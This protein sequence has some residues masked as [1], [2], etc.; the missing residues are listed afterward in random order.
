M[1]AIK[2]FGDILD[3]VFRVFLQILVAV[4]AIIILIQ[5]I[6]RYFLQS[7][8]SWSEELAR[9]CMIWLTFIGASIALKENSLSRVDL[10]VEIM[11]ENVKKIIFIITDLIMLLI[12][13]M[14][15]KYSVDLIKLPSTLMQKSAS[16]HL[17][18]L[19]AYI[20]IPIGLG[21]LILQII[22]RCICIFDKTGEE[23]SK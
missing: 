13:T 20:F 9:F 10:L 16:L 14:L 2:T 7:P 23:V 21:A 18:M 1:K 4:M 8:L 6:F 11:P 3:K 17:P 12:T 19:F 5:V 22:I 15:F